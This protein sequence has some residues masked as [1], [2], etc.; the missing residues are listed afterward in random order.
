M[1]Q[2]LVSGSTGG[3]G[4]G[5]GGGAA[6]GGG[7]SG[8]VTKGKGGRKNQIK[9][10]M[11]TFMV[12]SSIER[13]K[14]VEHGPKLPNTEL[15]KR[16]GQMWKM[17]TEDDKKPFRTEADRLRNKL[18]EEHPHYKYCP[19][20][21]K[22]DIHQSR[23]MTRVLQRKHSRSVDL[24]PVV[25]QPESNA[26][27]PAVFP[28]AAKGLIPSRLFSPAITP[29]GEQ[30]RVLSPTTPSVTQPPVLLREVSLSADNLPSLCLNDCP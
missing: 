16:L 27:T 28:E 24:T 23:G 6:R 5:D 19:W 18:M 25:E 14:V 15:T 17:M 4:G 13:K 3:E 26:T 7:G 30:F 12:W 9:Q 22:F 11:N 20:R 2:G 8:E 21:R 1:C 29:S 10:P